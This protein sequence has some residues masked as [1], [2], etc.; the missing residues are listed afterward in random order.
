MKKNV[1]GLDR[2]FR[3]AVGFASSAI[4]YASEDMA[5]RLLFGLVAIIGLGTGFL[6]YCPINHGLGINTSTQK[7]K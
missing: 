5:L 6:G 4:A 3:L 2:L 1:G 7:G